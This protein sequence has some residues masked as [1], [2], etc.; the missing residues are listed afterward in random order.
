MLIAGYRDKDVV[1]AAHLL[2]ESTLGRVEGFV[3]AAGV[4][5]SERRRGGGIADETMT[6]IKH[7]AL[8]FA[9]DHGSTSVIDVT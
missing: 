6:Q 8:D 5:L 7:V 9:R 4:H 2:P 1:A 3:A